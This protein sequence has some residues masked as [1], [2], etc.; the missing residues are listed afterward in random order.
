MFLKSVQYRIL[1]RILPVNYYLN[2]INVVTSD[3]CSLCKEDSET[4]QHVF[5]I[6][7]K[8]MPMWNNLSMLIYRKTAKRIGFN[9]CNIILGETPLSSGN[10]IVI[11]LLLYTKQYIFTCLQQNKVPN[12]TGLMYHLQFKHEIEKSIFI[13]NFEI[14]KFEKL[15]SSWVLIFDF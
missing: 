11:F 15:W 6:C 5:F 2:K 13:Q 14:S 10:R 3:E 7:E 9:V 4:K 1:H 12:F 8:V